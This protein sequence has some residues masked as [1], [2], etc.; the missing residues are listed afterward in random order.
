MG[1][2]S[3]TIKKPKEHL[4][5]NPLISFSLENMREHTSV[6]ADGLLFCQINTRLYLTSKYE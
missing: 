6:V 4:L 5:W 3:K 2:N 1:N